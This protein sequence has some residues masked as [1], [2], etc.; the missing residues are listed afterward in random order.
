MNEPRQKSIAV[1]P[2]EKAQ[3]ERAK[4]LY[5]EK[6]GDSNDWGGFL[7]AASVLA[8]AALGVYK[9]AKSTRDR[10]IVE[11]PAC[12]VR[13]PVAYSGR[14]PRVVHIQCPQCDE[15]LVVDLGR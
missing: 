10:P 1:T 15:E 12:G 8:L 14:P 11:C 2:R 5:E 7:A 13:F 3:L 9:L 6:T 4:A